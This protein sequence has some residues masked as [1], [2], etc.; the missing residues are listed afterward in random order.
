MQ[1]ADTY[2]KFNIDYYTHQW[3]MSFY[4]KI[5]DMRRRSFY[6]F[7][8]QNFSLTVVYLQPVFDIYLQADQNVTQ[9]LIFIKKNSRFLVKV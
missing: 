6:I 1:G 9:H 8:S 4:Y 3:P 7:A 5:S 2:I